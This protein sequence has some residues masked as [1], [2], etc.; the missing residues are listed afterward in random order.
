HRQKR[1]QITC[2]HNRTYNVLTTILSAVS[3]R[4]SPHL[5]PCPPWTTYGPRGGTLTLPARKKPAAAF[6]VMRRTSVTM[7]TLVSYTAVSIATSFSIRILT[8][9]GTS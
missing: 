6:S 1:E 4:T 9:R 3:F 8:P 2:D 7:K 5:L